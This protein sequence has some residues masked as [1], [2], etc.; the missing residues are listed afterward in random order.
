M[1]RSNGGITGKINRISFGKNKITVKTAN[2]CSAVTTQPATRLVKTLVVAGGGGGGSG[3]SPA[4]SGASGGGAGGLR[5][6]EL[7]VCGNTA[8]GAGVIG[9]G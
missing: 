3:P 6:L 9:A 7:P 8:L 4:D 1:A 2:A 5:N